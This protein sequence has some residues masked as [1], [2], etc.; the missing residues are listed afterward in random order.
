MSTRPPTTPV[1]HDYSD[2]V[3]LTEMLR[4]KERE[5]ELLS[6]RRSAAAV[7][8]QERGAKYAQLAEA[9][10]VSEVAVYKMLRGKN[11]TISARKGRAPASK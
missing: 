10:N 6:Q 8:H 9:M 2:V 5:I 11:K 4:R 1:T 7:K 3:Q